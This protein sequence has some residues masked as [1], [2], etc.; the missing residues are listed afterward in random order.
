MTFCFFIFRYSSEFHSGAA[1]LC[2]T[3]LFSD[4]PRIGNEIDATG[5]IEVRKKKHMILKPSSSRTKSWCP[6]YLL[7][8]FATKQKLTSKRHHASQE[9]LFHHFFAA[10]LQTERPPTW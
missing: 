2:S 7:E 3:R 1:R 6:S 9:E 4:A 5:G 10:F 8:R